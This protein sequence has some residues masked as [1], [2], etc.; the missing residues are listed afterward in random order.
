[1]H[2]EAHRP[3]SSLL[4]PSPT[5]ETSTSLSPD[6]I[7]AQSITEQPVP[8]L[9]CPD[10]VPSEEKALS[11]GG[12]RGGEVQGEGSLA[13]GV[14]GTIGVRGRAQEAGGGVHIWLVEGDTNCPEVASNKNQRWD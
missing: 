14:L 12:R 7:S 2:K 4:L 5:M 10:S 6:L 11:K 1:M 8:W 3:S 13:K 9:S